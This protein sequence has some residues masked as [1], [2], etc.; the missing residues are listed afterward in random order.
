MAVVFQTARSEDLVYTDFVESD[1]HWKEVVTSTIPPE[2][3]D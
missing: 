1:G 3:Q 2:E